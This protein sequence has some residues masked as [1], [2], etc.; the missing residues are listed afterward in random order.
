MT[1][2]FSRQLEQRAER[3]A[4]LVAAEWAAELRRTNPVDTG[5]M[6]NRTTTRTERTGAGFRV[7]AE[8][9]TDYAVFV[10]EGTRPHVIRPRTARALRFP[11]A[12]GIVFAARVNHPGTRPNPWW[13]NQLRKIP[14]YLRRFW[15]IP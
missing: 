6:R 2:P 8:V 11:T 7:T 14:D 3:T 4:R 1:L 12:N 5:N 15:S 10:S 9:D 13:T